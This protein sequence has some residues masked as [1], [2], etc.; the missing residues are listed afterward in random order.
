MNDKD[1]QRSAK[2]G[3]DR[4]RSTKIDKDGRFTI[5]IRVLNNSKSAKIG[6][7]RQRSTKIDKDRQ[8]STKMGRARNFN[9]NRM[10][11]FQSQ[12]NIQSISIVI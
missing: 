5:A 12:Q 2:I 7:D 9:R 6:K 11:K 1:R 10:P 8:R 3:I 4:Q